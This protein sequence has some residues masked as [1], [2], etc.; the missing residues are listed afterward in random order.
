MQQTQVPAGV[1]RPTPEAQ[2]PEHGVH[3][4]ERLYV[5][6]GH[7]HTVSWPDVQAAATYEPPW[8][9]VHCLAVAW[10]PRQ[11]WLA[12]HVAGVVLPAA[13]T[14]PTG[15]LVCVAGV[16]QK[17]PA[18]QVDDAVDPATQDMPVEQGICVT[19][20]GQ[21]EPAGQRVW[22]VE[23]AAQMLPEAQAVGLGFA[24]FG[25][26]LPAGQGWHTVLEVGVHA[27]A[28]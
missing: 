21:I 28:V 6:C 10:P 14:P 19:V 5:P 3:T 15:Q 25:Q 7:R 12:G 24:G 13:Q 22:F 8:H 1:Q 17:N 2:V 20:S 27:A 16:G 4:P 23:P 9:V 11:N 18:G 26:K